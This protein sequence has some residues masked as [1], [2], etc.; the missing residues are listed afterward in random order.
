M[1]DPYRPFHS[2]TRRFRL[3]P[4]A[5]RAASTRSLLRRYTLVVISVVTILAV[6]TVEIGPARTSFLWVWGA[7]LVGAGFVSRLFAVRRAA[8]NVAYELLVSDRVLHRTVQGRAAE[9]L[10]P[11]VSEILET[12]LGLWVVCAKPARSLFIIRAIDGFADVCEALRGWGTVRELRGVAAIRRA[13]REKSRHGPRDAVI[14]TALET[15]ASLVAELEAV[16][17]ASLERRLHPAALVKPGLGGRVL[18][19]WCLL[20]GAFLA[21]WQLLQPSTRSVVPEDCRD[22]CRYTGQCKAVAGKCIAGDDADCVR[23][24]T[25]AQS[26]LCKAVAGRCAPGGDAD[27]WQSEGCAKTGRCTA[28]GGYCIAATDDECGQTTACVQRGLCKVAAGKCVAETDDDCKQSAHCA[29]LGL[30]KAVGGECVKE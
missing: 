5:Y 11:E 7:V 26:G 22:Q 1:A 16:R 9:V 29:N 14:G 17:A 23:S 15:D 6:T 25:C 8:A 24:R 10:R 2:A 19:L 4:A 13:F 28:R 12:P 21:I 3:D 18:L 30:C 27:C 20:V